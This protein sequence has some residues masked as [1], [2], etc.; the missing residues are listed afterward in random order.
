MHE[1]TSLASPPKKKKIPELHFKKNRKRKEMPVR[2]K[3]RSSQA[4]VAYKRSRSVL[5]CKYFKHFSKTV[6]SDL[7]RNKRGYK[8][9]ILYPLVN[10]GGCKQRNE[11]F[12][13]SFKSAEITSCIRF[14][15]CDT[16][17]IHFSKTTHYWYKAVNQLMT[18]ISLFCLL[19]F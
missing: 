7:Q 6:L 9:C 16:F 19:P 1:K 5:V 12:F 8:D 10:N 18:N 13:Y 4:A 11:R 2:L 17:K 15:K 3:P 14:Y